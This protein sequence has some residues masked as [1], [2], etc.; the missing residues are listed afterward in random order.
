MGTFGGGAP[1]FGFIGFHDPNA[2]IHRVVFA[3]GAG[4]DYY[5]DDLNFDSNGASVPEPSSTLGL[6]T[7]GLLGFGSMRKRKS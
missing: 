6:L 4:D 2:G 5:I 7:F 3:N 1:T